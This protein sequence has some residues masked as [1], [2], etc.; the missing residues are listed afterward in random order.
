MFTWTQHHPEQGHA[1]SGRQRYPNHFQWIVYFSIKNSSSF[2][3]RLFI[4]QSLSH[5]WLFCD[6]MDCSLLGSSVYGIS[7]A[8]ILEWI[9]ISISRG[10]SQPRDRNRVS[11]IGITTEPPGK[12]FTTAWVKYFLKIFHVLALLLCSPKHSCGFLNTFILDINK[13]RTL[14]GNLSS[15]LG[16]DTEVVLCIILSKCTLYLLTISYFKVSESYS[17]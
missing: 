13:L 5:V 7:Q 16:L 3:T 15:S 6:P 10:S 17:K 11:H 9:A 12:P 2:F 4:V 14:Q 8:R 1:E